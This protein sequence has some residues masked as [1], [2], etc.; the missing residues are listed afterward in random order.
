MSGQLY[1][2]SG[3]SAAQNGQVVFI[4][5]DVGGPYPTGTLTLLVPTIAER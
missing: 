1:Q 5:Y 2:I 3:F 4:Y